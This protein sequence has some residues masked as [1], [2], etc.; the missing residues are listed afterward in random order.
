MLPFIFIYT[1]CNLVTSVVGA[2]VVSRDVANQRKMIGLKNNDIA[3]ISWKKVPTHK[4][5]TTSIVLEL[6]RDAG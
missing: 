5:D 1:L 6:K 2:P 4:Q 3:K